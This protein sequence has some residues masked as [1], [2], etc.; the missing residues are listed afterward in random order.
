MKASKAQ[1]LVLSTNELY[2]VLLLMGEGNPCA[3][4]VGMQIGTIGMKNNIEVLQTQLETGVS[5]VED[6]YCFFR[7]SEFSSHHPCQVTHNSLY[8]QL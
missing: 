7:G 2:L 8:L 4:S 3:L 6:M 1:E 5:V